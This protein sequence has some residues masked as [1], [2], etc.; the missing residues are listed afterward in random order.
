MPTYTGFGLT[1][2]AD[3]AL[4]AL[5]QSA[6]DAGDV[7]VIRESPAPVDG[8]GVT[9]PGI[10]HVTFER[11]ELGV[12]IVE[13]GR[14]VTVRPAPAAGDRA[15]ERYVLTAG[16]ATVLTQRGALVLHANAIEIESKAVLIL[17]GSGAGKSTTAAAL[18]GRGHTV[19]SDDV[20]AVRTT[21]PDGAAGPRA[22]TS[23][24]ISTVRLAPAM[25]ESVG[26]TL[27]YCAPVTGTRK[28]T[29]AIAGAS[30]RDP[31]RSVPVESV[32]LLEPPGETTR[33]S[34]N[35]SRLS[36]ARAASVL[37][38]STYLGG[39]LSE[40]DGSA[41]N[42]DR[43]SE[44]LETAPVSRIVRPK[45]ADGLPELCRTIERTVTREQV[46]E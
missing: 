26:V 14:R 34:P 11:P 10:E 41:S 40:L 46:R 19:L 35:V 20:A 42:L 1:I 13:H 43:C 22:V 30:Q 3:F 21:A 9:G 32:V 28:A 15:L 7:R 31:G 16:L 27:E 33:D 23:P 36:P 8:S 2:D 5:P 12:F 17:G 39:V 37:A 38:A 4:P 18:V 24:G 25:A 44:L 6:S 45:T 29:Y